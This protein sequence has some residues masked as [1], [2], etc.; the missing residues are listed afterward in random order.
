MIYLLLFFSIFLTLS[1]YIF[2]IPMKESIQKIIKIIFFSLSLSIILSILTYKA[3]NILINEKS[4]QFLK[5]IFS[6]RAIC[7][8]SSLLLILYIIIFRLKDYNS[9]FQDVIKI[10][11]SILLFSMIILSIILITGNT[12]SITEIAPL[13]NV[14]GK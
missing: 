9:Q 12:E 8:Y 2:K 13:I 6:T 5:S 3:L 14:G 1:I 7:I 10:I 4:M 11:V